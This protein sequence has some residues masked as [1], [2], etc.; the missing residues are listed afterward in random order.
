MSE[1]KSSP[2]QE[3]MQHA[4]EVKGLQDK[5]AELDRLYI[6]QKYERFKKNREDAERLERVDVTSVNESFIEKM[7]NEHDLMRQ[8]LKNRLPFV[9]KALSDL[10][11]FSYPNLLLLGAK[12]GHGKST[13]LANVAYT[14]IMNGKK[15]LVISNEEMAV[16][17]YNRVSCLHRGYNINTMEKFS[18]EQHAELK[19]L[20]AKFYRTNRLKVID[21]DYPDMR[22]ATIT[23]EGLKF[24][25]D[26]LLEEQE[27][28][29][30]VATYDA[31]LIDYIQKI[32]QSRDNPRLQGWEVAK[33]AADML[34]VFY[35][36]YHAPV[37][38]F[39]QL[40]PEETEGQ[41]I[42]YRFKGGKSMYVSCTYCL[43]L[44]PNKELR[45]TDFI[46]H[47]HRFNDKVNSILELAL[48]KGKY[49]PYTQEFK[50][51]VATESVQREER[52]M[53]A[54]VFDKNKQKET[55]EVKG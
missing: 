52:E 12:T 31:I 34:D 33:R 18:D 42:E 49:V 22:D 54:K 2:A 28:N 47:K 10:V 5:K 1:P 39:S 23:L 19:D 38:V 7:D 11:P 44:K 15:V 51:K 25:T 32:D 29:G 30:G 8:S 4:Q 24:I 43:E 37:V 6:E 13:F 16:N 35:K 41:D 55:E 9:N 45:K 46:V 48:D 14:L 50:I 53:M 17:V 40:K 27:R 21:A 36:K 3:L 20:R 26:K